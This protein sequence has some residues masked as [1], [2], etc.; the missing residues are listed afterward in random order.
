MRVEVCMTCG[1]NYYRQ[2]ARYAKR[3]P[4]YEVV[5]SGCLGFCDGGSRLDVIV[6]EDVLRFGPGNR[7]I[8]KRVTDVLKKIETY[9]P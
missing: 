1:S 5:K 8:P 9:L 2:L 3:N 7:E 6:G 4:E